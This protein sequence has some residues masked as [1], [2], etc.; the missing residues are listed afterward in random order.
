MLSAG[1]LNHRQGWAQQFHFG[2]LRNMNTRMFSALGPDTGY[3]SIGD[4]QHASPLAKFLD[5]L[6]P[7]GRSPGPSSTR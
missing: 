4:F 1:R 3:D 2:V 6:E 5:R 7:A